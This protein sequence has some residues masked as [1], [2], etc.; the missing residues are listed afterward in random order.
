MSMRSVL[1]SVLA[2]SLA[3]APTGQAF[4]LPVD[5]SW[6][7]AND[8][9]PTARAAGLDK[10]KT[11][12]VIYGE[13]R[14]FDNIY[15]AFPGANGIN[16]AMAQHAYAQIDRNGSLLPSLPPFWSGIA[17]FTT[18]QTANTPNQPF[19]IDAPRGFR[20]SELV[21][22]GDLV[23]RFYQ[24]QMQIHNGAN[25]MYAAWSDAGGLT[26]SYYANGSAISAMWSVAQKNVLA[27]NFF[28]GAFG[29]S[30][31]NHQYLVCACAPVQTNTY[32]IDTA[33]A[34]VNADGVSLQL[35]ANNPASALAGPPAY[36]NDGRLTPPDAS[37]KRHAINTIYPPYQPSD[38]APDANGDQRLATLNT[39]STLAPVPASQVTIGDLLTNAN[40][41]WAWYAGAWQDALN[42]RSHIDTGSGVPN[43]Q[44][45]HQPFNYYQNF[46]PATTAG[47]AN[48]AKHLLDG[49]LAGANF[50]ADI[51]AGKLP[52]VTFYKPQGNL[53]EHPG[54][55]TVYDGD[56]HIANIISHLQKSSQWSN[57]VVIVTYDENGGL[58]DHAAPPKGDRW[59]PGT[60]IPAI[61]VSPFVKA[62]AVDHSPYDTSSVLRLIA[63]RFLGTDLNPIY[64]GAAL[65]GLAERDNAL[66]AN[67]YRRPADFT[68]ALNLQ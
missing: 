52:P 2:L 13:N 59:G 35:A 20:E 57:M 41:G 15:G 62:G 3:F 5:S 11:I 39:I 53:N 63:K 8:E 49:G 16:N 51:D 26:M 1:T 40:V 28:Q 33:T 68:N 38:N 64:P 45:H 50:I 18:A 6:N 14:S 44:T 10:I 56:A 48:R 55:A 30:F 66:K 29:G 42:N 25:D 17:G 60:R 46:D 19:A 58:W 12:V 23:H 31:L 47:A 22:T 4:A 43:F 27:D 9:A 24:D 21:I 7:I 36:V 32:K 54:Y 67:G 65:P 34:A 61:V 37:G